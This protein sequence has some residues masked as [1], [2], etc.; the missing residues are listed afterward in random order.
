MLRLL[1]FALLLSPLGAVLAQQPDD[2]SVPGPWPVGYREF[3]A[4]DSSRDIAVGGRNLP[5]HV[6]YPAADAG[7]YEPAVYISSDFLPLLA[8][9]ARSEPPVAADV[10]W[11]LIVFSHGFG[12][13]PAQSTPLM[14]TLASHGFVV[15]A[16]DHIGNSQS[17]SPLPKNFEQARA[18]RVPDVSFV[19]DTL[20]ALSRDESSA[21]YRS[22]H[23]F[24]IGVTGHS[25]GGSTSMGMA[26]GEFGVITGDPRVKAILPVSGVMDDF[27][28][29]ALAQVPVPLLLLGATLDTAVPIA[30]NIRAFTLNQ[31]QSPVWQVDVTGASHT[32]QRLQNLYTVA[33]FKLHIQRDNRYMR[34]L[35]PE[36]NQQ[37]EPA[38]ALG[39]KARLSWVAQNKVW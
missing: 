11:P 26:V 31:A 22:L 15:A 33:F 9:I 21:W 36:Y 13:T 20:L 29:G 25:F 30:N 35:K 19:I 1:L 12:G 37:N 5:I 4:T 3:S 16:V 7:E 38:I 24:R 18:D 2:P 39:R 28:D 34:F 10:R 14:E 32:A 17:A 8:L 23:P 6:W 27:T